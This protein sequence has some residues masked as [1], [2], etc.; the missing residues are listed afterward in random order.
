MR[1]FLQIVLSKTAVERRR[2]EA[3]ST[4]GTTFF[5]IFSLEKE[6]GRV[7]V[8]A[9]EFLSFWVVSQNRTGNQLLS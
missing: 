3:A 9:D 5:T 4:V 6:V 8:F 2:Q 7:R 1:V